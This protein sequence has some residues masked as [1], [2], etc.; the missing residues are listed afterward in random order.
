M[1]YENNY[2]VMMRRWLLD[3]MYEDIEATLNRPNYLP[4]SPP[5]EVD[6]L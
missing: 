2:L 6:G 1:L 5:S 3:M 4:K